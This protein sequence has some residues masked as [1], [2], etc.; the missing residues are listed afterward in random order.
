[1]LNIFRR[2][3]RQLSFLLVQMAKPVVSRF[4]TLTRFNLCVYLK[5]L[6]LDQSSFIFEF[7]EYSSKRIHKSV[8]VASTLN[9]LTKNRR[10][11]YSVLYTN[12]AAGWFFTL[13]CRYVKRYFTFLYIR[14]ILFIPLIEYQIDI[15]Q[16]S[17]QKSVRP[18]R[19]IRRYIYWIDI[20]C[21]C[22]VKLS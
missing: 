21:L 18:K 10:V 22:D 13:V 4:E 6:P 3:E 17:T 1:M 19:Y 9:Q 20:R 8:P 2:N 11:L 16:F 14:F 12:Q 15:D 5:G 7:D